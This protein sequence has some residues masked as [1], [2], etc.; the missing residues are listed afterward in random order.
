M[1]LYFYRVVMDLQ[2][3][4]WFEFIFYRYP[5]SNKGTNKGGKFVAR[6]NQ[7]EISIFRS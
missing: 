1:Q 7:F 6:T 2:F 4:K 5:V 3:G